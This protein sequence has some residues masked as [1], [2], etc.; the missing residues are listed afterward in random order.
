MN[1]DN[2]DNPNGIN[3]LTMTQLREELR[4]RGLKLN[5]NKPELIA[6]LVQYLENEEALDNDGINESYVPSTAD[7]TVVNSGTADATVVNSDT[8]NLP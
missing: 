1:D 2:N 3:K 7:A 5:G 6:Q 8:T 4:T